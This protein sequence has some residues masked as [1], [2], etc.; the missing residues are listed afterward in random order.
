MCGCGDDSRFG[1]LRYFV[2]S[3]SNLCYMYYGQNAGPVIG[4]M[5]AFVDW[6]LVLISSPEDTRLMQMKQDIKDTICSF[7]C[8][9]WIK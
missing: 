8:P 4:K 6:I 1:G 5:T 9:K 7:E 3:G 2:R